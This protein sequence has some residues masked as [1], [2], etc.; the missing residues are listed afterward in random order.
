M[1]KFEIYKDGNVI[2]TI[3]QLPDVPL[4]KPY[5]LQFPNSNNNKYFTSIEDAI[6]Y[7]FKEAA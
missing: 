7:L 5:I 1:S 2:G 3:Y 6:K 4:V